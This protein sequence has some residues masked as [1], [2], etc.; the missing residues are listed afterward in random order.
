MIGHWQDAH[1]PHFY[2]WLTIGC[3][4]HFRYCA[5]YVVWVGLKWQFGGIFGLAIAVNAGHWT[6]WPRSPLPLLYACAPK[7]PW[8]MPQTHLPG[9]SV[10]DWL[11]PHE[12]RSCSGSQIKRQFWRQLGLRSCRRAQTCKFSH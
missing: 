7:L 12:L 9:A 4:W 10:L 6:Q 5:L 8:R 2:L 11:L 3:F 1:A